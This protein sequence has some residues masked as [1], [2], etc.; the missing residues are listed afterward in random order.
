[1][2]MSNSSSHS[3]LF[4]LS[5]FGKILYYVF[6]FSIQSTM[7]EVQL[8]APCYPSKPQYLILVFVINMLNVVEL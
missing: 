2:L 4:A 3:N 7:S 6:C 5:L 1:M 8:N